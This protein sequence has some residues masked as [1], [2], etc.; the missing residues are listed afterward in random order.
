[1]RTKCER[2][3]REKNRTPIVGAGRGFTEALDVS[4]MVRDEDW[5]TYGSTREGKGRE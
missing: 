5:D 1:M 4:E 3:E 2:R